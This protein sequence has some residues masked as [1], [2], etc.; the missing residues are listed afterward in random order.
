ME[1]ELYLDICAG[2]PRVPIY[3]TADGARLPTAPL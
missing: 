3:A 2:V 1:G